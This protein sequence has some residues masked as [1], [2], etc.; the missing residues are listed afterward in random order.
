LIVMSDHG[1]RTAM[2]HSRDAFFV[3]V[4]ADVSAGRSTGRPD[5]RGVP[6]VVADWLGVSTDWPDTGVAPFARMVATGTPS[7][8]APVA[9]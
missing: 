8:E 5:L 7:T 4:S 3:A 2:E 9:R 1:I 6:R